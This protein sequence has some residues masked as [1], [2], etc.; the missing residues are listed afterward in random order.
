MLL[1]MNL[2]ESWVFITTPFLQFYPANTTR[3]FHQNFAVTPLVLGRGEGSPSSEETQR[4][5]LLWGDLCTFCF[6]L[7][8][9]TLV[10]SLGEDYSG[11]PFPPY[12]FNTLFKGSQAEDW[13]SVRK[14]EV[15]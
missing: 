15:Y 14:L 8:G 11:D 7:T 10:S 1:V 4:S 6:L 2:N 9:K 5:F 13:C 3:K 12:P